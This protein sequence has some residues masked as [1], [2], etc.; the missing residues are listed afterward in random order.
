[1]YIQNEVIRI[2]REALLDQG[3]IGCRTENCEYVCKPV[4]ADGVLYVHELM[5]ITLI[6]EGNGIYRTLN[7]VAPCKENDIF[8]IH[9]NIPHS[10][11]CTEET[12]GLKLKRLYFDPND[13]FDGEIADP[14]QLR[15]CY[16]VFQGIVTT[17]YA[18]LDGQTRE[19]VVSLWNRI[20]DEQKEESA[21]W[22]V[23][24][25]SN[26]ILLMIAVAR[27]VNRAIKKDMEAPRKEWH[28]VSSVQAIV[29]ER[30][31]DSSLTL[32]YIADSL[33]VSKSYLSRLFKR[34]TGK[35][36]SEYL[37]D[38]RVANA[39]RLLTET[40]MTVESIAQHCGLRDIP[41]F[42]RLIH[43][44]TGVTPNQFRKAHNSGFVMSS[45]AKEIK[46][47][48]ILNDISET[49]QKGKWVIV[50]E[51]V[52]AALETGRHP[53][54]ILNRGLIR[55]MVEL[56]ERFKNNEVYI[57]EVLI[58]ARAMN[59]GVQ[60]LKPHLIREKVQAVGRVCIGT[61]RGDLH[62]IGKNLV[63][64][65]MEGKGLEV[66]DLGVDV[67]PEVF[68]RTAVEKDCRVICCSALLTTALETMAQVVKA[69]EAAGIRS[70]VK[71]MVGG[72]PVT[73]AFCLQIGADVYTPD[74]ASAADAAVRLCEDAGSTDTVV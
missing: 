36:Y 61:V 21:E 29:N 58:A 25:R 9:A 7:T 44:H 28:F 13:W 65:M 60:L 53:E 15:Y 63:R 11:C 49:V 32:E 42:Y 5:E 74:A 4:P 68:V 70:R 37:C 52:T 16:G 67:P 2:S 8:V 73:E 12:A 35:S 72:A 50:Q 14:T 26:L 62:D 51:L 1:M 18:L 66:I 17:A 33:Y 38:V 41:S 6:C 24:A 19:T 3:G 71:I 22:Q 23:A 64:M 56:G 55:G 59:L 43:T 34:A 45:N 30:F 46:N 47:K 54:E 40:E 20:I 69:A 48:D 10:F 39:C 57:P 31:G 27:Y